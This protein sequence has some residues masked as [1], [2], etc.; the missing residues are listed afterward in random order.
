MLPGQYLA[1]DEWPITLKDHIIAAQSGPK[2]MQRI[3]IPTEFGQPSG[4]PRVLVDGFLSSTGRSAWGTPG[5][6]VMDK[7]GL[8]FADRYNGTVWRLSAKPSVK[9]TPQP[10]VEKV[11]Q[12]AAK[13]V[14][15]SALDPAKL[16]PSQRPLLIG[17]GIKG[18]QI[19]DAS[20]LGPAS[21][22]ETGSTIIDAYEKAEA[23][24]AALKEK[25]VKKDEKPPQKTYRSKR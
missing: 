21:Q 10:E 13:E 24:A 4:P 11:A 9:D 12:E 7:R 3:A 16:P 14:D 2:A 23:E 20:L 25:D 15:K 18:S 17:S 8:F 5:A 1:P 6:M 19:G 22:L